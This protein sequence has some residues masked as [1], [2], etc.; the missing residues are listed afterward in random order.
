MIAKTIIICSNDKVTRL[1]GCGGEVL[2]IPAVK[3][4]QNHKISRVSKEKKFTVILSFMLRYRYVT[5]TFFVTISENENGINSGNVNV[6]KTLHKRINYGM[7]F[8]NW[9][10]Y[11]HWVFYHFI[12]IEN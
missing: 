12:K 1:T 3:K 6:T 11:S 9:P 4:K 8:F 2:R 7:I 5:V 10:K